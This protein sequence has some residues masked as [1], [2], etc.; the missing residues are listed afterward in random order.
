MDKK[1]ALHLDLARK[2]A[3]DIDLSDSPHEKLKEWRNIFKIPQCSVAK[4]MNVSPSIMSDYESGRRKSPGSTIIK[5]FVCALL[6]A[7]EERNCPVSL[8]FNSI[9][10]A[11]ALSDSIVDIQTLRTPVRVCDI[12][13]AVYGNIVACNEE[14]NKHIYGYVIIDSV[15]AIVDLSPEDFVKLYDHIIDKVVVFTGIN[16]GKSPLV[17]IKV[18]NIKPCAVVI[19]GPRELDGVAER[20]AKTE[21]IPVILSYAASVD[22]LIHGLSALKPAYEQSDNKSA[23]YDSENSYTKHQNTGKITL[24]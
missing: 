19:H 18:M 11:G 13:T 23:I 6:D 7:D 10:T 22:E 9:Y 5:K 17:A 20:I 24:L 2:I 15:K 3:G 16:S 8:E 21:N 14:L 12:A 1:M 4:K